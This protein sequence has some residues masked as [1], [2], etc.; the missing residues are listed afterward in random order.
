MTRVQNDQ[1]LLELL[2][3]AVIYFTLGPN[4]LLDDFPS[5]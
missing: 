1:V 3:D 2:V 4:V 5:N